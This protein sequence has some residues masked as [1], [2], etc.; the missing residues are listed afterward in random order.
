[1]FCFSGGELD[2]YD[3]GIML[4]VIEEEVIGGCRN[5]G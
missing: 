4:V 3:L 2:L 1:M 5:R